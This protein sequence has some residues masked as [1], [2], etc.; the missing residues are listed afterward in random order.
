MTDETGALVT[1]T[2]DPDDL[3]AKFFIRQTH[4]DTAWSGLRI[5][6]LRAVRAG[7]HLWRHSRS[8][9]GA[10]RHASCER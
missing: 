3:T 10:C 7:G 2:T 9:E 4:N 5:A 8:G 6:H 1:I